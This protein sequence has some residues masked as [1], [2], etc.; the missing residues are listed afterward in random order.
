MSQLWR[1]RDGEMLHRDGTLLQPRRPNTEPVRTSSD[2]GSTRR[3]NS[4]NTVRT[5]GGQPQF[6]ESTS[7]AMISWR[8]Q[9]E[10]ITAAATAVLLQAA[11]YLALNQRQPSPLKGASAPRLIARIVTATRPKREA[12]PPVR[13]DERLIPV[14]LTE[15]PVVRPITPL[16]PQ[17]HA[18][19]PAIDRLSSVASPPVTVAAGVFPT[20]IV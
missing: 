12:P 13:A 8:R 5:I 19:R 10:R 3:R 11:L 4:L 9:S 2:A 1:G 15:Q 7:R 16:A 18:S 6:E 20:R 17:P 14:P